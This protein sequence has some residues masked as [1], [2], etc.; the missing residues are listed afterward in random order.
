[1]K[2]LIITAGRG[3]RLG[4]L[5]ECTPK[6][7]INVNEKS[8]FENTV[9]HFRALGISDIAA[10]IGY[11]KEQ[12]KE[13]DGIT[14]F[15]NNNWN[16]NNILHS[17]FYARHFMD[18]DLIIAYGDIWFEKEPIN[19]MYSS[20]GD[21][22][23]AV[24]QDWEDYYKGRTDHPISEAENVIYN[25]NLHANKIGKHIY[26]S[27]N[28]KQNIGEFMG[29]IKISKKI[30]KRIVSEFES[31]ELSVKYTDSF[32]NAETFQNAYLTDFIQYLI[33][34]GCEVNC[35]INNRGWY[36]VDTKQDLE[37]LRSNFLES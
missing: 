21:F 34:K 4:E 2:G 10:I 11:K 14:F 23:I 9:E 7:L 13:I 29:L 27:E 6:S 8:F 5:T 33:D 20:I 24:D 18:D 25:K 32:Q 26:C 12:F 30:I 35:C 3:S 22:I 1:M 17:L 15:E 19:N 37:N 31:L 28:S 16:N 36:E